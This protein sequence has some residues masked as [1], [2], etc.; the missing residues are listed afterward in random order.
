LQREPAL[1]DNGRVGYA[2]AAYALVIGSLVAYGL[3]VQG[4]RRALMREE[5][6]RAAGTAVELP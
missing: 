4:Q 5:R 1:P 3:W 6:E 2:I